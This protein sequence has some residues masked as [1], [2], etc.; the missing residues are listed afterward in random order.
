MFRRTSS[1]F[2]GGFLQR[3]AI[4]SKILQYARTEKQKVREVVR[5][6][7]SR[8]HSSTHGSK[9]NTNPFEEI[10]VHPPPKRER[11]FAQLTG[12]ILT[13]YLLYMSRAHGK[14]LLVCNY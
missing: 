3:N 1:F 8:N 13:F 12:A 5:R 4:H 10:E 6:V 14:E 11:F 2:N 7:Q 9:K